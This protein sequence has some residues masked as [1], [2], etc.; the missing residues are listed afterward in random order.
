MV[1]FFDFTF[2]D[3]SSGE[4][5][6]TLGGSSSNHPPS[7]DPILAQERKMRKCNNEKMR[8]ALRKDFPLCIPLLPE[9]ANSFSLKSFILS[10]FILSFFHSFIFSF[11]HSA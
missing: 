6:S 4:L 3:M 8:K 2:T 5:L 7:G 1:I 11:F 10:F 9:V